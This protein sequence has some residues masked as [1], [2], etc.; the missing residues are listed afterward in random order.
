MMLNEYQIKKEIKRLE[1]IARVLRKNKKCRYSI[2]LE[3]T[4]ARIK[5]LYDVLNSYPMF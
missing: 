1:E 3:R 4:E 2:P 5:T